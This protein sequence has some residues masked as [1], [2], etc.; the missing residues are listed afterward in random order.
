MRRI[1]LRALDY[2][3]RVWPRRFAPLRI[4]IETRWGKPFDLTDAQELTKWAQSSYTA[5]MKAGEY[6]LFNSGHAVS[7]IVASEKCFRRAL[8]QAPESVEALTYLGWSLD[9]QGRWTEAKEIYER[10]LKLDPDYEV[11]KDRYAA[12]REELNIV[13]DGVTSPSNKRPKFSRFPKTLAALSDLDRAIEDFVISHVPEKELSLTKRTRIVTI[14]SCFAA[15]LAHALNAE[16]ISAQNLT[17]G[18]IINS[19]FANLEFFQWALGVSSTVNEEMLRKFG[20]EEVGTLLKEADV[21]IYTLGVAPCFFDKASGAFMLPKRT[22]GVRGVLSGKY[23][24]RTTTVEENL[25]NLKT[26]VALVRRANPNC[27]FVFSL[28][29]VPL[30]ST[31]EP[32]AAMEADCLSKATL[33]VAV[34]Q[35]V[36]STPDCLY[37]PAFEIVRWLGAYIPNMY[38]DEDGTAHHVSERVVQTIM[39]HF[40][41]LYMRAG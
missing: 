7:L 11:A 39:G 37:W 19:T 32:R 21:V 17:V 13:D 33:R 41:R 28:S 26:I 30:T 40:L 15:N 25:N 38:G 9:S 36:T 2:G 35:L 5:Q 4:N 23:V 29:P 10:V 14:G 12:A 20:R 24:F 31:L 16:G 6:F 1:T 3:A 34:D 18:E 27:K 8:E 22:E